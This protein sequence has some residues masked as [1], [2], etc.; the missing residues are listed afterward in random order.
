MEFISPHW[1]RVE[2]EESGR[3]VL[4]AQNAPG[5]YIL[6]DMASAVKAAAALDVCAIDKVLSLQSKVVRCTC[7]SGEGK[8]RCFQSFSS[9]DVYKLR[10]EW[11][12]S[13]TR[14]PDMVAKLS[15]RQTGDGRKNNVDYFLLEKRVCRTF[16][17]E[18]LGIS[19]ETVNQISNL[20]RGKEAPVRI[21]KKLPTPD[22]KVGQ[23]DTCV[24]FW[25]HW[26]G[27][28]APENGDGHRYYPVNLPALVI[29]N[30]WFWPWWKDEHGDWPDQNQHVGMAAPGSDPR[31]LEA[32]SSAEYQPPNCTEFFWSCMQDYEKR[33]GVTPNPP[34]NIAV[35]EEN[36]H[37]I[38]PDMIDS[39][40]DMD[41]EEEMSDDEYEIFV[42]GRKVKAGR[43]IDDE[44]WQ[45]E[46]AMAILKKLQHDAGLPGFSTFM[47]ARYDIKF[48]DVKRREKHF[49]C[50]CPTCESL[51][52]KLHMA[53]HNAQERAEFSRQLKQHH[54]EIKHWRRLERDWISKACSAPDLYTVLSYDDTSAM[55]FPRMTKRPV[56][57]CPNDKFY[58]TPWNLTNHGT[59]E[60]VYVYDVKHKW[61]HG[62]D[63]LCTN[64][65]TYISRLK[66]RPD[67][68]CTE[69]EQLQ[70]R[71]RKLVLMA[72]NCAEN[73]NNIVFAFM[74]E[75][76]MRGWYDEVEMLFGPVGHTHNG[77]DAVHYVHNNLAGNYVSITPAELFHNYKYAW[78]NTT[79]RPQPVIMECQLD[80]Q[81]HYLPYLRGVQGFTNTTKDCSYVRAF[82]F[83][84]NEQ[85]QCEMHVKGSPSCPEWFGINSVPNATGFPILSGIP[86]GMP[87]YKHP[88]DYTMPIPYLNRLGGDKILQYAAANGRAG[89][90]PYL[91]QMAQTMTVPSY[92]VVS[93]RTLAKVD[94]MRQNRMAGWGSI[95]MI[96]VRSCVSYMVPFVRRKMQDARSFWQIPVLSSPASALA[97]ARQTHVPTPMVTEVRQPRKPKK[98]PYQAAAPADHDDLPALVTDSDDEPLTRQF[99]RHSLEERKTVAQPVEVPDEWGCDKS[100]FTVGCFAAV[101]SV[102]SDESKGIAITQVLDVF[103]VLGQL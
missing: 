27:E 42:N 31:L 49:H 2:R 79:T 70:K 33:A 20:V 89:M 45:N 71:S 80:W 84:C 77:N 87:K 52:D 81:N 36:K 102:F 23:Y 101:E 46:E 65:F 51:N 93:Q 67:S 58:M 25:D 6:P 91:M 85:G 95:E 76:V 16:F 39:E 26:F 103:D 4:H 83:T 32:M 59:R 47:N 15:H 73:K 30:N 69:K 3:V 41:D 14:L 34:P 94:V 92:G 72:D 7:L 88:T 11:L 54:F 40:S 62:A 55:G 10:G 78:H 29:Y 97:M 60:N 82:R 9:A 63:R 28:R 50:R 100:Q 98:K 66:T 48:K 24:R 19:K 56:K 68:E 74:A 86:D 38:G 1:W 8:M 57:S 37:D 44:F 18:C 17:M 99:R 13:P 21:R 61:Q 90:H 64:L 35:N 75:L 22:K 43:S 96:G 12:C 53:C 5:I